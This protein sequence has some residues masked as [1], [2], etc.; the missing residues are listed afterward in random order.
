MKIVNWVVWV[1]VEII[2][3]FI[4]CAKIALIIGGIVYGLTQ[5][6]GIEYSFGKAILLPFLGAVFGHYAARLFA[7]LFGYC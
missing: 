2:K 3:S 5:L 4:A 7:W 1:V 6:Y